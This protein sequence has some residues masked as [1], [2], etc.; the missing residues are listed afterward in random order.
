VTS[1]NAEI[2]GQGERLG[3]VASG[4]LADLIAVDGDP[5]EDISLL[6]EDGAAVSLVIKNGTIMKQLGP[7]DDYRRAR[8]R[9]RA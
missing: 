6:A 3:R 2:I 9:A 4:Y 5:V 1:V 7:A 8:A